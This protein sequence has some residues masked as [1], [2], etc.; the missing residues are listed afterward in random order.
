MKLHIIIKTLSCCNKTLLLSVK[1]QG[2]SECLDAFEGVPQP[3]ENVKCFSFLQRLKCIVAESQRNCILPMYEILKLL[4]QIKVKKW[5]KTH[6]AFFDFLNFF[7]FITLS[8]TVISA[9]KQAVVPEVYRYFYG[10]QQSSLGFIGL[11]ITRITSCGGPSV[12]S[13]EF[14]NI[15]HIC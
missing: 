8:T 14:R 5:T 4:K 6:L 10:T 1:T 3:A 7:A 9:R 11:R 13:P 2:R 12:L 15:A